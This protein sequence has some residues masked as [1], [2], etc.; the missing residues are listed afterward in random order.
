MSDTRAALQTL[1]ISRFA[2]NCAH[3][4][5]GLTN[6][7]SRQV[8]R[9]W[10]VY[11]GKANEEDIAPLIDEIVEECHGWPQHIVV[12]CINAVRLLLENDGNVT[13]ELIHRILEAGRK[14]KQEYYAART[15]LLGG[16]MGNILKIAAHLV[17]RDGYIPKTDLVN[18][19]AES[20]T[21]ELARELEQDLISIGI[22]VEGRYGYK[23]PTP[24]MQTWLQDRT[25]TRNP[26][27]VRISS[28]IG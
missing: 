13:E 25:L 21:K 14:E 16:Y 19:I 11:D 3:Q 17:E 22:I 10:L 26:E 15:A 12:F 5:E 27:P 4:L 23:F 24:S 2:R 6:E 20:H 8:I 1:G 28:P 7:A 18:L 9:D